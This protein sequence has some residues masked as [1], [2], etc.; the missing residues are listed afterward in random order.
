[1]ISEEFNPNLFLFFY[2]FTFLVHTIRKKFKIYIYIYFEKKKSLNYDWCHF[3]NR[4]SAWVLD[5]STVKSLVSNKEIEFESHLYQN[6]ID[7]LR[8]MVI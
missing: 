6:L 1:M 8:L 7:I 3:N 5:N 2:F 4:I